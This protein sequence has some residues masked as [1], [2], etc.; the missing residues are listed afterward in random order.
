MPD[1]DESPIERVRVAV[2]RTA[3]F[4]ITADFLLGLIDV[5]A[6]FPEQAPRLFRLGVILLVA[7]P[8]V[9]I[10]AAFAEE[11]RR[12]DRLFAAAA[13]LVFAFIGFSFVVK[14]VWR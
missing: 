8:V 1:P 12:K 10:L 5:V 2:T 3:L 13:A 7:M 9:G 14:W 4:V 6:G 11:V